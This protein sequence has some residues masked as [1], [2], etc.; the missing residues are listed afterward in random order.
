MFI[1]HTKEQTELGDQSKSVKKLRGT[2][3]PNEL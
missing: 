1:V 3:L 2:T